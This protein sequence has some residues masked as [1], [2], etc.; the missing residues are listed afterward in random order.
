MQAIHWLYVSCVSKT[1][2][3]GAFV[4]TLN[5]KTMHR[6]QLYR[7]MLSDMRYV[8]VFKS[9]H[10]WDYPSETGKHQFSNNFNRMAI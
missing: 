8:C 9:P 7:C 5:F 10:R 2:L 6:Q 1:L 4:A 3:E